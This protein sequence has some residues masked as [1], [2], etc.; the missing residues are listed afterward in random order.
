MRCGQQDE[1]YPA[2]QKRPPAWA[3]FLVESRQSMIPK[4]PARHVMRG[5][6]RF[7]EKDML[8]HLIVFGP[9]AVE[10]QQVRTIY[11]TMR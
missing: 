1:R 2:L 5:G 3:A 11:A 7:S 6:N 10:A 4:K 9:V 8:Q